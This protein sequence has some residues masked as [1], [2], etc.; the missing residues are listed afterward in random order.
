MKYQKNDHKD[1]PE[2][3]PMMY[4]LPLLALIAGV[5]TACATPNYQSPAPTREEVEHVREQVETL[6]PEREPLTLAEATALATPIFD[7]IALDAARICRTMSEA[8]SCVVPT[9]A[10]EDVDHVNAQAG[11]DQQKDP[12]ISL[13]RGL[14]E[15]LADQ[16]DELALVIGHQYGHLITAH[17]QEDEGSD[18][19]ANGFLSTTLSILS[20]ASMAV[21]NNNNNNNNNNPY[22][23]TS[24]GPVYSQREIDEYLSGG[25]EP[26]PAYRSFSKGQEL[27]ADYIGTYLATRSGYAPTG[28]AFIEIG[29]LELRDGQTAMEKRDMEIPFAFWDTHPYSPERAARIQETVE[30][31]E[32]LKAR[33]YAR[34]IPPRLIRD[35]TDNNKAFHSLEELVAPLP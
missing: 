35:I 1:R 22:F 2:K 9:F 34:P 13:T 27:E 10:V 4:R 24:T 5:C 18:S 28:S 8:D 33:G 29:A 16:Q 26:D 3:T 15:Y 31:I 11:F 23:H 17:I 20:A 30:E 19:T 6:N 21:A 12:T 32:A 14:V 25:G 7:A